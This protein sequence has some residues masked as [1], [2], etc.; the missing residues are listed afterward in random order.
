VAGKLA[1]DK[2]AA[3]GPSMDTRHY[4]V[5]AAIGDGDGPSQQEVAATLGIDRATLVA[6]ADDLEH[7]GLIQRLRRGHDR[8]ADDLRL[9]DA[10]A[11]ALHQADQLMDQC[12]QTFT[13]TLS[14][15]ERSQLAHLL[16]RLFTASSATR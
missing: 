15:T 8:R 13:S 16:A 12:E 11:A 5:L 3:L 2:L 1:N 10:G 14:A 7:Q 4:A 6:L 9:T